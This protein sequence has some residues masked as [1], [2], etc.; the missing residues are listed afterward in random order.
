MALFVAAVFFAAYGANVVAGAYTHS[1][2]LGDVGE[3]LLL[4]GASVAFV[5]AIL[6]REAQAKTQRETNK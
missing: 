2:F 3:M 4:W 6:K 5:V 1:P